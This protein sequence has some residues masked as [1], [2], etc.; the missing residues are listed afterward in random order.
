[1][2]DADQPALGAR[3]V[4]LGLQRL[5][6][7]V[8]Q[9]LVERLLVVARVVDGAHLG[10]VGELVRLDEVPA[11]QL[12]R[13]H[14]ELAGQH[15]HAALDEVGRL[16]ATGPAIGVGRRLVGEHLGQVGADGGNVVGGIRH[17]RREGRNRRGQQ[18]VVGA[19]V[20]DEPQL[21]PQHL[22]L[23]GGGDVDVAE[24]AAPVDGRQKRLRP[25][26]GPLD[27]QPQSLGDAGDDVLLAVDVDLR[28]EAATH[29]RRDR[30][31]LVLPHAVHGGDEGPE[32]VRV[33]GGGPDGHRV[34]TR[35]VVRE[36]AARLHRRRSEPLVDHPLRHHHLG[37][38]ERLVDGAVVDRLH[39]GRDTGAARHQ[40]HRE[41]VLEVGMDLRRLAGHRQLG[42]DHRRQ[43]LV[44]D[45]DGVGGV[46]RQVTVGG[47]HHRHRLAHIADRVDR[48]RRM[49]G[50]RE[51]RADRH[52]ADEL[53]NLGAGID[54]LDPRHRLGG[55]GVDG[56]DATMRDVAA[57]E[58][59]VH[60][61]DELEVVDIG[62]QPL[63]QPRILA[64][65]DPGAN[66]L[67]QYW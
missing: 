27:R 30:P 34:L 51:R 23:A 13:I 54:R 38:G 12:G 9:R 1:M 42:I 50:R 22:A 11:A 62:A 25:V 26:L 61:A 60:H 57:L 49:I 24:D 2:T 52:R 18:H 45:D 4:A 48:H 40:R 46:A 67:R 37:V 64:S 44:V 33:L 5:P 63:D 15:V 28:A 66:Q 29:L 3:G 41:V 19:D 6:A 39:V 36:D 43:R 47:N 10:R 55:A 16:G 8:L 20:G 53:R 56:G 58:R 65:L 17:Q 32:D 7:G 59:R 31:H 14:P 21:H 35:F